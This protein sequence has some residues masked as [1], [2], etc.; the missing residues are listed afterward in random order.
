MNNNPK[1]KYPKK[2]YY[3]KIQRKV[4]RAS[5]KSLSN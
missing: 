4:Q 3:E 2:N 1:I 5:P